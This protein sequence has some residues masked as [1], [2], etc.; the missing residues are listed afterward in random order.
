MTARDRGL[1]DGIALRDAGW[2][3]PAC[4]RLYARSFGFELGMGVP[5]TESRNPA[6]AGAFSADVSSERLGPTAMAYIGSRAT[7][8]LSSTGG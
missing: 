7:S 8:G 3:G 6:P 1:D 2:T 5:A 4:V